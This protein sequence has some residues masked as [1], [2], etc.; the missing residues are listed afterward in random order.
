MHRHHA[1]LVVSTG[2]GA[3]VVAVTAH[4]HLYLAKVQRYA[5]DTATYAE[6]VFEASPNMST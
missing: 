3:Y 5:L 4:W 6:S 2:V 1:M